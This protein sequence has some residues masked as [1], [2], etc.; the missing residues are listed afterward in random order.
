MGEDS[1]F[2]S[3]SLEI[4]SNAG[5]ENRSTILLTILVDISNT[6]FDPMTV[7]RFPKNLW[8]VVCSKNVFRAS[9]SFSFITF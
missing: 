9:A 2:L 1:S 5:V 3:A 4:A 6:R 7:E 8:I